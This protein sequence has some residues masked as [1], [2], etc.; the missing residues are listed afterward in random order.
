MSKTMIG[1]EIGFCLFLGLALFVPGLQAAGGSMGMTPAGASTPQA[2]L[3]IE[4]NQVAGGMPTSTPVPTAS[5]TPSRTPTVEGTPT[6][7]NTITRTR[8]N[9]PTHTRPAHTPTPTVEGTPTATHT[10]TPT[11][12]PTSIIPPLAW[13]FQVIDQN[14]DSIPSLALDSAGRPRMSYYDTGD[15]GGQLHYAWYNGIDWSIMTVPYVEGGSSYARL[16]LDSVDQ[17]H[18]NVNEAYIQHAIWD[19]SLWWVYGLAWGGG[20]YADVALDSNNLRHLACAHP[21]TR[22]LTY[23]YF[24]TDFYE[25]DI[26]DT[27]GWLYQASIAVDSNN[28][29]HIAYRFSNLPGLR[30]AWYDGATWIK[31]VVTTNDP[32]WL[33]LAFDSHDTP[34]IAY[35]TVGS[36][37]KLAW[38]TDPSWQIETVAQGINP[39]LAI[40]SHDHPAISGFNT[41]DLYPHYYYYDG[42]AWQSYTV[43]EDSKWVRSSLAFDSYDQPHIAYNQDPYTGNTDLVYATTNNRPLPTDT[44]TPIPPSPTKTPTRRGTITCTNTLTTPSRTPPPTSTPTPPDLSTATPLPTLTPTPTETLTPTPAR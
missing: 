30:Y 25:S 41:S 3:P 24:S 16:R 18:I 1:W 29:P 33:S 10:L 19:G 8:E 14:I 12:T 13:Y 40:D 42:S 44:Q 34:Y 2:Y 38:Y 23:Y 22:A 6:P 32:L 5:L 4:I 39:S 17:P 28:R 9:T 27:D 36:V 26:V 35:S 43:T 20:G 31:T 7:T 37:I 11:S 15:L 21:Y